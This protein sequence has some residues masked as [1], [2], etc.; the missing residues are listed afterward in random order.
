VPRM[1]CGVVIADRPLARRSKCRVA[2]SR[3]VVLILLVAVSLLLVLAGVYP[4][5]LRD[6]LDT[7]ALPISDAA[8]AMVIGGAGWAAMSLDSLRRAKRHSPH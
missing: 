5:P 7:Q 4:A 8:I 3:I 2:K 6:L 1:R